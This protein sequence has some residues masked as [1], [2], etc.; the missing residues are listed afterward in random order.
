VTQRLHALARRVTSNLIKVVLL[1]NNKI[2]VKAALNS[3]K[4]KN[5]Y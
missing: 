1:I 5:C 2:T 4:C 3:G